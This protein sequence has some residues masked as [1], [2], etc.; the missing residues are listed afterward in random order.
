MSDEAIVVGIDGSP[1]AQAALAWAVRRA[2]R[3][4]APVRAVMSWHYPSVLLLPLVGQA[5]PP[6]ESMEQATA[7]ALAVIVEPIA[8]TTSATV[9]QAVRQG[10][11]AATLLAESEHAAL[12]VVGR[13]APSDSLL[14]GS[15]SRRVAAAAS[16]PVVVVPAGVEPDL[17]G[18]IVVG[19]DGSDHSIAAIRWA[20]AAT[21]GPIVVLHVA[22]R[23]LS[24]AFGNLSDDMLARLDQA[25]VDA[26]VDSAGVDRSRVTTRVVEGDAREVLA[27]PSLGA[28]LIVLGARGA[29]GLDALVLGSVATS[30]AALA[31]VPVAV[32]PPP[33]G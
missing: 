33:E 7:E 16:C 4:G 29:T 22:G 30:V 25:V 6:A 19:V 9:E 17:D 3:T 12:V 27:D 20:A 1:N 31:P 2:E 21:D 32:V 8:S 26:A 15:V 28:S 24:P 11:P 14:R 23:L 18:P 5:V 13:E 10:A